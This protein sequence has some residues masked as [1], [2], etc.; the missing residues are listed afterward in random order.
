VAR[1]ASGNSSHFFG[2]PAKPIKAIEPIANA[3]ASLA[4]L[5]LEQ[6]IVLVSISAHISSNRGDKSMNAP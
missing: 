1:T 5:T 4:S 3:A 6:F 2:W